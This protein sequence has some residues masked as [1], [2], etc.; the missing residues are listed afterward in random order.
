MKRRKTEVF[1]RDWCYAAYRRLAWQDDRVWFRRK[2]S[3]S[4]L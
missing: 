1:F 4:R 3:W 2:R